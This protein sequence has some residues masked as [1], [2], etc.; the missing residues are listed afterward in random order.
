R[1][2][3]LKSDSLR[4][5]LQWFERYGHWVVFFG[6]MIPAIRS[7]ISIPAGISRMP[8]IKF[9]LYSSLGTVIWTSFLAYVGY[10]LGNNQQK[11]QQLFSQVS[12]G[13][14]AVL[15][16]FIIIYIVYR[17]YRKQS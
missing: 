1:F 8:F 15:A 16:L 12:Y 17:F 11:M 14:F 13:I 5:S 4:Q 7:L 9:M 6:R 2:V 10:Y 3:G